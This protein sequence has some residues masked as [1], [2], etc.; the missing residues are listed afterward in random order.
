MVS[1]A[2]EG[3]AT[4]QGHL[5]LLFTAQGQGDGPIVSCS[6]SQL[7][8]QPSCTAL[9]CLQGTPRGEGPSP[10]GAQHCSAVSHEPGVVFLPAPLHR[11]VARMCL[12]G[13]SDLTAALDPLL[14]PT[15]LEGQSPG[16]GFCGTRPWPGSEEGHTRAWR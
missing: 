7:Q 3:A 5:Q 1:E 12:A 2:Q 8:R 9:C 14:H 4:P 6:S 11:K 13:Q 15:H 16:A 10:A